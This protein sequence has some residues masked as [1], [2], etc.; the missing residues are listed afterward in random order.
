MFARF[1]LTFGCSHRAES[2]I[3]SLRGLAMPKQAVQEI[4]KPYTTPVLTIYGTV[5]ELT[6]TTGLRATKDG[7]KFPHIKTHM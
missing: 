1:V 5:Q 7:G 3:T 6:Q 2:G 4:K